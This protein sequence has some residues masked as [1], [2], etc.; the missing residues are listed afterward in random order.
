MYTKLL[1]DYI[2]QKGF[3]ISKIAKETGIPYSALYDSLSNDSRDRDLRIDE[4][5]KVCQFIGKNVSDFY[6]ISDKAI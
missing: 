1:S 4:F 6:E 5:V 3:S 2:K